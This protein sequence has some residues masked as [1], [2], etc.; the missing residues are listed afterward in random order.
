MRKQ[1]HS[2]MVLVTMFFAF[3][4]VF[5]FVDY[6]AKKGGDITTDIPTHFPT[7]EPE[8]GSITLKIGEEGVYRNL[9]IKPVEVVEDSRCPEGVTCVWAGRL[10][11]K[12]LISSGLGVSESSIELGKFITTEAEEIS[13]TQAS[14]GKEDY[15]FTF[16]VERR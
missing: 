8:T 2:L 14:V 16:S 13:L 1:V 4:S 10:V 11:V 9:S 3:A 5:W 7:K 12:L 15:H 6:Y